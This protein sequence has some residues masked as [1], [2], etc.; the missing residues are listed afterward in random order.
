MLDHSATRVVG[1]GVAARLGGAERYL[2]PY[3]LRDNCP[4]SFDPVTRERI[5]DISSLDAPPVV[6]D[7]ETADAVLTVRWSDG[8]VSRFDLAWLEA[9]AGRPRDDLARV[10]RRPWAAGAAEGFI[11]VAADAVIA[12]PA[13]RLRF[14]EALLVDGIAIATELADSDDALVQLAES[15]GSI[16]P[17]VAGAFFDVRVHAD[18]VNLSY[19]AGALEPHTDTPAEEHPPGIQ[20]LHVRANEVEGGEGVYVDGVAVADAFRAQDPEGFELLCA[21]TIPFFYEHET[22]DWRSRQR[23]IERD[24][25][26]RVSGVTVSVHMADVLDLDQRELDRLY[27]ALITFHQLLREPRFV[28]RL[29]ME[30]GWCVVFDNHR[31]VHGR[32]AYE[33]GS[34]ERHLRGC[35]IDRGE[36]RST[37]RV[38]RRAADT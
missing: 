18:P 13:S 2:S 35:Y 36:L 6:A 22:F 15:L 14:A 1:G 12:D 7:A 16:R 8:H 27:P 23:V 33:A 21:T 38:L 4:S 17:S 20:F 10:Q 28:N 26:G 29:R 31:V 30:P 19:T 3:W 37:Y 25:D 24:H 32:E 5:F 11:R 34:G 9:H